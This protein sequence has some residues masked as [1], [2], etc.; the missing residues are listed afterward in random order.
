MECPLMVRKSSRLSRLG[1]EALEE[2]TVLSGS[3]VGN[4]VIFGDSLN[5]VGNVS[6]VSQGTLPPSSLYFNTQLPGVPAPLTRFSGG[7]VWAETLAEAVGEPPV[8]PSL[9]GGT[10]YS[11]GGASLVAPPIFQGVPSVGQ[12]VSL[13]LQGSASLG[14]QAHTPAANDLFAF[15]AGA[16]DFFSSTNA[17]ATIDPS[18]PA[19]E[20]AAEVKTLADAGAKRFVVNQLPPLGNV[21][22]F[23][24]LLAAGYINQA[25]IDNINLWSVGFNAY[26]SAG[27]A[28]VQAAH[29]DALII[30]EDTGALFQQWKADPS[31]FGFTD[32]THAVGPYNSTGGGLLTSI[33]AADASTHLFWDSVHPGAH[34]H[35]LLG[36]KAA[37]DVLSALGVNH[38]TVTTTADAVNPLDGGRSLREVLA[39]ADLM[40]GRQT[41]TFDLGTGAKTITL[42]GQLSIHDDLTLVGTASPLTINGAGK[43]RIFDVAEGADVSIAAM[44]LVNG[45][46]DSGGAI[47]NAGDLTLTAVTLSGNTAQQGGA[48]YNTGTLHVYASALTDNTASGSTAVGGAIANVGANADAVLAGVLIA[49]NRAVGTLALGGGLATTDGASMRV[50][51][52][53]FIDNVAD[54]GTGGNARGGAAYVGDDSSLRLFGTLVAD[55]SAT[56]R[57]SGKGLGGGV[58]VADDAVFQQCLSLVL[59]NS[60]STSGANVYRE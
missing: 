15:W 33:T 41:V 45:K 60:S 2:R 11:F 7:P 49:N 28:G 35:E 51:D 9:L 4:L 19:L 29:P 24:D 55:N 1:L 44:N 43:G 25:T 8:L 10:D 34:A 58:F 53:L 18:Q 14:L 50:Y 23:Q 46:A 5:D 17:G 31:A 48:I 12:Q 57:G 40:P 3:P 16:N 37:A 54:G 6:V 52:S 38:L 36:E 42:G 20:L 32:T 39:V 22:Y 13:Y 59:G 21:P 27:L 30:Q 47:R 26:L 56:E